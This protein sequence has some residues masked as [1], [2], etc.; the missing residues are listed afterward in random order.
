MWLQCSAVQCSAVQCSAEQ[1]GTVQCST[2][3]YSVFE[4]DVLVSPQVWVEGG[5]HKLLVE[6]Q[7]GSADCR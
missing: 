3:Q 1:C 6:G 4:V 5:G 2:V 7:G